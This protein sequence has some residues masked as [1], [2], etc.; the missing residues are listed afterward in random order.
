MIPFVVAG[1]VIVAATVVA[2]KLERRKPDAPTQPEHEVP[3]QLDRSDFAQP[4]APWLVA[5]FSS[6]SCDSCATMR[7][8]VEALASETVAVADIEWGVQREIHERYSI[9]AVP[10]TVIAD[11]QG[12]VRRSFVGSATATDLWAAVAELREPGST[13]GADAGGCEHH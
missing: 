1:I 11:D 12:V 2:I 10:M 6:A 3:A 8:K 7:S 5:L 9:T 4:D 13:P